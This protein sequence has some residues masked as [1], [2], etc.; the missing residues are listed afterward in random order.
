MA[1]LIKAH[2]PMNHVTPVVDGKIAEHPPRQ[3]RAWLSSVL[4]PKRASQT[5]KSM[6]ESGA[7]NNPDS[8]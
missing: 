4:S 5:S 6:D 3:T 2:Q 1:S 8:P 7:P